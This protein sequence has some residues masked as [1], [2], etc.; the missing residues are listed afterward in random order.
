MS[1]STIWTPDGMDIVATDALGVILESQTQALGYTAAYRCH[2]C[3]EIQSMTVAAS[4]EDSQANIEDILG[5]AMERD[6]EKHV[7]GW[8]QYKGN[9]M[10][11]REAM[12]DERTRKELAGAIR[13]WRSAAKKRSKS[14]TGKI[15]F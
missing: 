10:S 8:H 11:P 13:D 5:A 15:Y 1:N 9:R 7:I 6:Y 4:E 14:S 2:V 3:K 12:K